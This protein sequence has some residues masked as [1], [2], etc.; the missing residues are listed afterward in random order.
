MS[1]IMFNWDKIKLSK[2]FINKPYYN[3][4]YFITVALSNGKINLVKQCLKMESKSF[5]HIT[6]QTLINMSRLSQFETLLNYF[7]LLSE[8]QLKKTFDISHDNFI[9]YFIKLAT[10]TDIAK[11]LKYSKY[12][13]FSYV[14]DNWYILR[15]YL[16]ER[17]QNK[18]DENNLKTIINNSK[19]FLNEKQFD[20]SIIVDCCL[21]GYNEQVLKILHKN[22]KSCL[23]D[24]DYNLRSPLTSA[25]IVNNKKLIAFLLK[26]DI[27]INYYGKHCAII[28]AITH[29]DDSTILTLL[30]KNVNL[31]VHNSWKWY[32]GHLIFHKNCSININVKKEIL[33]NT[34]D[35]N[36]QNLNGNTILHMICLGNDLALYKDI[37]KKKKLDLTI[38][39]IW[40][41]SP[42]HYCKDIPLLKSIT[43]E[44]K[45]IDDILNGRQLLPIN[46][47]IYIP[48][49]L[50]NYN[51]FTGMHY[52]SIIYYTYFVQEHNINH[53]KSIIVS[54]NIKISNDE[55][56]K[57]IMEIYEKK[58][59]L[60]MQFQY[61]NIIWYDKHNYTYSKNIV[62]NVKNKTGINYILVTL[63]ER[64]FDHANGL[65]IDHDNKRIL[66][67]EPYGVID[68]KRFRDF[69][70]HAK[71]LFES[72][73]YKYYAPKD[74][75]TTVSFQSLSNDYN[76]SFT[77]LGDI[78]GF[79]LAWTLWFLELYI[80]NQN[81]KNLKEFI[82]KA[83]LNIIR[84]KYSFLQ[85]IRSYAH[86][87]SL[88]KHILLTS[89]GITEQEIYKV[90]KNNNEVDNMINKL[91]DLL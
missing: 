69:D 13:P 7:E 72:L 28:A 39:D 56:I 71:K 37:L 70:I 9:F 62:Q 24:H 1:K 4:L 73:N 45:Y 78:G 42:I 8:K 40:N 25:I 31:N 18:I 82:D 17:Y 48:I 80:K 51:L 75:L 76:N 23:S 50:Q 47:K 34:K 85:Y 59:L 21:N 83:I 43:G 22:F 29:N 44:D 49:T 33:K 30:K 27:D 84:S 89:I 60:H 61:M 19:K 64:E 58:V 57:S 11:F 15:I 63:V 5:E 86:K 68:G 88:G 54:P 2:Q 46:D 38:C 87:L 79:C 14:Y 81:V 91:G 77:Q 66:H 52:D 20:I 16:V 53:N 6:Q 55:E 32:P 41:A 74:Y 35:I 12:I 36:V 67:F 10:D 90:H 65:I 3:N 26:H